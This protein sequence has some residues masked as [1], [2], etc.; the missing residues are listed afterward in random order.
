[1]DCLYR[2]VYRT[3][4]FRSNRRGG[5]PPRPILKARLL[6]NQECSSAKTVV[7][8]TSH[9]GLSVD[10]SGSSCSHLVAERSSFENRSKGGAISLCLSPPLSV[11]NAW[12]FNGS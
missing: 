10:V 4:V 11:F 1:Q 12:T 6:H 8:E 2:T 9:V 3:V 7:M 5:T